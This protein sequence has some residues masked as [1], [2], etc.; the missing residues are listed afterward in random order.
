MTTF[1]VKQEHNAEATVLTTF[2]TRCVASIEVSFPF[3]EIGICIRIKQKYK[4]MTK[5]LEGGKSL[6]IHRMRCC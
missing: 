6:Q 1:D 5:C 3:E 2:W 4:I